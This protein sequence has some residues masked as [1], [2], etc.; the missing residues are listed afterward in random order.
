MSDPASSRFRTFLVKDKVRESDTITSFYFIPQD[1]AHWHPFEAGQFLTLRVPKGDG[2]HIHRNY[3][4][5]SPPHRRG[6][7][8]ISVKR[9]VA[10]TPDVP[11][12]L[13]SCWLHDSIEPGMKVAID[14]PHGAF[15]LNKHSEKPVILLS[16]GVGLTPTVSML[17]VLAH[18][19]RRPVWF[20]HA[21]DGACVHA[22]RDEVDQLAQSRPDIHVH[23]CYRYADNDQDQ[24]HSIGLITRQTLQSIL[25]LDDYEVYMCGPSPF[26][27]ALYQ[28]LIRLGVQ[29]EHIFYEFFGPAS[30]LTAPDMARK[31]D[32]Q[33]QQEQTPTIPTTA[34]AVVNGTDGLDGETIK[35]HLNKSGKTLI[36]NEKS[37]SLLEFLES[38][39]IEPEFSCRAGICST[40]EQGILAGQVEYF[41]EPLDE[42]PEGRLLLCCTRPQSSLTLDL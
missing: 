16:G 25:P 34:E 33:Q 12:G 13:S 4:V 22:L 19:T 1:E 39:G 11:S 28:T 36:W 38:Q 17:H 37:R 20:I 29:R 42:M 9:E 5:S 27:Q 10:P 40:C 15:K 2:T 35:I 24:C 23:Y 18:E 26:M 30:L 7:Y 3:T 21:C 41:E 31:T 6:L 8:R 14:G 32:T